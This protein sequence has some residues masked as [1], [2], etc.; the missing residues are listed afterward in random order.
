MAALRGITMIPAARL[1]RRLISLSFL[2][3]RV[4]TGMSAGNRDG[5]RRGARRDR[6]SWVARPLTYVARKPKEADAAR[7]G[8]LVTKW[9]MVREAVRCLLQRPPPSDGDPVE[10]E[11]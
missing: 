1:R 5:H 3:Q 9:L 6:G 10:S 7:D 2:S 8:A 11:R 4:S